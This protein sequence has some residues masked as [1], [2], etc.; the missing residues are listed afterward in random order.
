[1]LLSLTGCKFEMFEP[2]PVPPPTKIV[3]CL[4]LNDY[5]V[6][7]DDAHGEGY[8]VEVLSGCKT[9]GKLDPELGIKTIH[10]AAN[11]W[12]ETR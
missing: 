9:V 12:E 6:C 8:G 3:Y 2:E 10:N 11:Y 7:C 1:M 5:K 4:F